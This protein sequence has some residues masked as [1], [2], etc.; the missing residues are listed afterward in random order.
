MKLHIEF[1]LELVESIK[2]FQRWV[3]KQVCKYKGHIWEKYEERD[4][5]YPVWFMR[6]YYEGL[7]K[8][9][10]EC[11]RC[12]EYKRAKPGQPSKP[13][14][15]KKYSNLSES[16]KFTKKDSDYVQARS[17]TKITRSK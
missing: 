2:N 11:K 9:T 16:G 1:D 10:H 8:I 5:F 6:D 17:K 7:G 14:K 13:L 15:I 12:G 4:Y 3:K